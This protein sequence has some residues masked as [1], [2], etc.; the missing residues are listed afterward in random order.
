VSD[1]AVMSMGILE[2][3]RPLPLGPVGCARMAL[4]LV[5]TLMDFLGWNYDLSL[6]YA[7]PANSQELQIGLPNQSSRVSF[8]PQRD[9]HRQI[10]LVHMH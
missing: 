2:N 4:D 10:P 9:L 1:Q 7:P 3:C 8:A 5:V 6:V